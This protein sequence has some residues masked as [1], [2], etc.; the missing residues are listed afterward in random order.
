MVA[1]SY[2]VRVLLG[3]SATSLWHPYCVVSLTSQTP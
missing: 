1:S 3:L 2:D